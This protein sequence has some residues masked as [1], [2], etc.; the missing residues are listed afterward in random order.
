M[1]GGC[2]SAPHDPVGRLV[3]GPHRRAA[4]ATAASRSRPDLLVKPMPGGW[5]VSTK[6]GS[7]TVCRTFDALVAAVTSRGSTTRDVVSR[8]LLDAAERVSN[9]P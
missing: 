5:T 7:T 8:S 6:T 1:C 9:H 4:I 3:S 2:G